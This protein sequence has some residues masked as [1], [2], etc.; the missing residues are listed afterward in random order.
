M[1]LLLHRKRLFSNTCSFTFSLAFC[2]FLSFYVGFFLFT[3]LVTWTPRLQPCI[4]VLGRFTVL[5]FHIPASC[6]EIFLQFKTQN[7][8]GHKLINFAPH[9]KWVWSTRKGREQLF[10][11]THQLLVNMRKFRPTHSECSTHTADLTS[12]IGKLSAHISVQ[13][14]LAKTWQ[15][16]T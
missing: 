13:G 15:A 4:S 6:L 7:F 8:T 5:Y 14:I 2:S 10:W 9:V 11:G 1:C 16:K 12:P 3:V